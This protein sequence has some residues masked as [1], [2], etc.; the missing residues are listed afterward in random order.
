[1]V[2]AAFPQFMEHAELGE[3]AEEAGGGHRLLR[4][5]IK[6]FVGN[7]EGDV[8]GDPRKFHHEVAGAASLGGASYPVDGSSA[9]PE[10]FSPY[11]EGGP[12]PPAIG[13]QVVEPVPGAAADVEGSAVRLG[14]EGEVGAKDSGPPG[15]G[16]NLEGRPVLHPA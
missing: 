9:S 8:L 6:K 2:E 13:I 1:M 4:Q 7:E 5:G 11:R 16:E 3:G 10:A 12:I 14:A 15:G